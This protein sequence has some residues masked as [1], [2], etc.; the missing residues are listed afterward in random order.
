MKKTIIAI[1]ASAFL[2]SSLVVPTVASAWVP[3]LLIPLAIGIK[4]KDQGA[5]ATHQ[6]MAAKPMHVKKKK[7][8]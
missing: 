4:S 1:T 3:L 2:A 5:Q 8:M 7:K 6:A